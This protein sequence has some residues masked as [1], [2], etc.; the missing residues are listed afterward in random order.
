MIR[1]LK[2]IHVPPALTA[3]VRSIVLAVISLVL[4]MIVQ[5]ITSDAIPKEWVP[6][7]PIVMFVL[8][9]V[10]GFVDQATKPNQN[11]GTAGVSTDSH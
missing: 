4:T 3:F 6:Y 8:R 5:W 7:V 2:G 1:A 11:R 10:E 9:Q